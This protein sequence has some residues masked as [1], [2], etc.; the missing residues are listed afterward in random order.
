MQQLL[1]KSRALASCVQVFVSILPAHSLVKGECFFFLTPQIQ[2][3][4]PHGLPYTLLLICL[5]TPHGI[6]FY[7]S[8]S[9]SSSQS[10]TL[11]WSCFQVGA[12]YVT[13]SPGQHYRYVDSGKLTCTLLGRVKKR[14][15]DWE[16][17][18]T[19]ANNSDWQIRIYWL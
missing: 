16:E 10:T 2:A 11:W 14:P 1:T 4:R 12:K 17:D 8:P 13:Q 18:H 5:T 9:C 19:C 6:C 3:V 7:F 15:R